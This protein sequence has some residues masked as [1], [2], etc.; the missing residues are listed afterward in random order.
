ML[1]DAR[2][3]GLKA[4]E[5]A[6]QIADAGGLVLEVRPSG[7]KVWMYRYRLGCDTE[8]LTIGPYPDLSLKDARALHLEAR[9]KVALGESPAGDRRQQKAEARAGVT[10]KDFAELWFSEYA[11]TASA[12]WVKTVRLWLDRDIVPAL[13]RHRVADVTVRDILTTLDGIKARGA[14]QSALRV[15]IILR[16][17][18][19]HA[20]LRQVIQFNPTL[21]VPAR[22]YGKATACE[23]TLSKEELRTFLQRLDEGGGTKRSRLTLQLITHTMV[24]KMEAC[25]ARWEHVDF[26]A[27]EWTIP[28]E[29]SKNGKPHVVSMSDQVTEIFRELKAMAGASVWCVPGAFDE[30]K[31][32]GHAT[33][34]TVLSSVYGKEGEGR[35]HHTIH[36]LRR[37]AATMLSEAGFSADVVEKAL[38]HTMAGVRGVYNRAAYAKQ[39]R[40]MLQFWSDYLASLGGARTVVIGSFG[41]RAAA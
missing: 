37:T 27:R 3:K 18:F 36:D 7:R 24:R 28:A 12:N 21:E 34:N 40:E 11:P 25:R 30:T 33:L 20:R 41:K 14:A 19:A 38:N 9:R 6:Y 26:E 5:R 10:V 1:N 8:K 16:Q 22:L 35:V 4:R 13:G 17:V 15:R 39:R 31:H 23:R 32:I 29:H 2:I